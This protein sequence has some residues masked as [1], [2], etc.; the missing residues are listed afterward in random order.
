MP[1][2]IQLPDGADSLDIIVCTIWIGS[3]N[4]YFV[5][6]AKLEKK[7]TD[8]ALKELEDSSVKC[9]G[10]LPSM[11]GAG[12][13][14]GHILSVIIDFVKLNK[15]YIGYIA[16]L[17]TSFKMYSDYISKKYIHALNSRK[18]TVDVGLHVRYTKKLPKDFDENI[19]LKLFEMD[20]LAEFLERKLKTK[21]PD[22]LYNRSLSVWLADCNYSFHAKLPSAPNKNYV[23]RLR[24][25]LLKEMVVSN[26]K[27]TYT[28]R[29]G[30]LKRYAEPDAN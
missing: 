4:S 20:T 13:G 25:K 17:R 2:Y 9:V 24:K 14:E 29:I 21:Y 7:M 10:L 18:T 30:F 5:D 23:Y 11:R 27:L 3:H 12:G 28:K 6:T 15:Q 22:F 19:G 26:T 16:A 8:Y 1:K